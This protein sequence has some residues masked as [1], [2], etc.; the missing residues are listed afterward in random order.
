MI[1]RINGLPVDE[2]VKEG[3]DA[4]G[5]NLKGAYN[6]VHTPINLDVSTDVHHLF[7]ID[8]NVFNIPQHTFNFIKP[9]LD[10]II[11]SIF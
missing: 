3:V 1:L 9:H 7:N 5:M 4:I 2:L 8:A 10:T 11:D 6:I